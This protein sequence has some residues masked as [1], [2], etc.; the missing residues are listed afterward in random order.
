MAV[1]TGIAT[2][3]LSLLRVIT[4]RYQMMDF[5]NSWISRKVSQFGRVPK[6]GF[7][8][9]IQWTPSSTQPDCSK[10]TLLCCG[11]LPDVSISSAGASGSVPDG[12]STSDPGRGP[13]GVGN[14]DVALPCVAKNLSY[15]LGKST[16]SDGILG[17]P[18][19]QK[20]M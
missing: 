6:S 11:S 20:R 13:L 12:R 16:K 15:A 4:L 1:S 10:S 14:V 3:R 7:S 17:R 19:Y 18:K 5:R 2:H 9:E 8:H